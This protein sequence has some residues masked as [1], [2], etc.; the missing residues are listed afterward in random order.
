MR[1]YLHPDRLGC[2]VLSKGSGICGEPVLTQGVCYD[3]AESCALCGVNP[4][5]GIKHCDECLSNQRGT[6]AFRDGEATYRSSTE[7]KEELFLQ[8]VAF[9][10]KHEC[11]SGES[12]MQSDAPQL[13]AAEFL[14]TLAD[15][16]LAF[17]VTYAD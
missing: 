2:I 15:E 14:S 5:C 16:V 6:L 12:I 3:H 9:F 8:V 17:E 4:C 13:H 1:S 7:A 10:E 11:F